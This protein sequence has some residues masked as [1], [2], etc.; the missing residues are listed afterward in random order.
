MQIRIG[1]ELVILV[2]SQ[3]P[4]A[5]AGGI[6]LHIAQNGWAGRTVE[7]DPSSIDPGA[8]GVRVR[9]G[10]DQIARACLRQAVTARD[11]SADGNLIYHE[12]V[13]LGD[14]TTYQRT[15]AAIARCFRRSPPFPSR[16]RR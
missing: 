12:V 16:R 10:E 8:A 4:N 15:E 3:V 11:D 9:A 14:G 5:T 7:H 13:V 2:E 6:E 1:F